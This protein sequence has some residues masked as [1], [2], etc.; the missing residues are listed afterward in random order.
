[1]I[2]AP[3]VPKASAGKF[4]TRGKAE[5]NSMVLEK[6]L[7]PSGAAPRAMSHPVARTL[8]KKN[9]GREETK[10][11]RPGF[12]INSES[13]MAATTKQ[14]RKGHAMAPLIMLSNKPVTIAA[15]KIRSPIAVLSSGAGAL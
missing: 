8:A 1:M 6:G 14:R 9:S 10:I 12:S 5:V 13:A 2:N 15:V 7:A 3:P 4:S 11:K